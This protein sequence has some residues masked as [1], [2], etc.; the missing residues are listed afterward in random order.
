M[1]HH[2]AGTRTRILGTLLPG[3]DGPVLPEWVARMLGEGLAGVCLFGE[4]IESAPQLRR[5]TDAIRAANP[6]AL[7]AI[8][9]EGGDVTRLFYDRGAPWPGNA[10]LGR[11]DDEAATAAV[12]TSVGRA[13]REAG[14]NLDFA[15]DADVNSDPLNPVI[16][17]RSFGAAPSLVARHVAAWT[18]ALQR[19]GVAA[20]VKHFPG[21]GDTAQDSHAELPVVDVT[22]E[23]LRARELVP[24]AAAVEAGA[25][26]VM[27]SHIVLPQVDP[28][29]PATFSRPL[30]QG[31]LREE[32]GFDG[33]VVSDALDMAG[34]SGTIG[35][36]AAAVR[37]LDA[38]CDLLCIGTKNT[39]AQLE[40][41][42]GQVERALADGALAEERLDDASGRVAALAGSLADADPLAG[43][44]P[45][46]AAPTPVV[47]S[48]ER[49]AASFRV[50]RAALAAL[51][52]PGRRWVVV[53]LD[54]NASP[55]IGVVPWGPFAALAARHPAALAAS[56][57]DIPAEAC[58]LAIGRDN[59]R[60]PSTRSAIDA[61]RTAHPLV[62]TVD[63]G[64]PGP[65]PR[66]AELATFGASALVGD[67]LVHLLETQ[68]ALR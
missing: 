25:A 17:V 49:V 28:T 60:H 47:P 59:E 51:G 50:D 56:A 27:T 30:L 29:G 57:T 32:L 31:V 37:A 15:P 40:E 66:Y 39:G 52:E 6:R 19:E 41:I 5:L 42:V 67:A 62:V 63:M 26:T 43:V 3:F 68:G 12:A 34:A 46:A 9:E 8:D 2:G 21:H 4:N 14:V 45:A 58:V 1:T 64:W 16:G 55:A 33:V 24:F 48:A 18:T 65:D 44:E 11:L 38:G 7:I 13:L 36:P 23:V 10:V 22:P 54:A 20:S 61:L 53:R 35:I